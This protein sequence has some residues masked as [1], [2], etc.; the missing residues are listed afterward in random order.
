MARV[1]DCVDIYEKNEHMRVL[2][3]RLSQIQDCRLIPQLTHY[4]EMLKLDINNWQAELEAQIEANK[5]E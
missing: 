2:L 4:L 5:K 1:K 3:E